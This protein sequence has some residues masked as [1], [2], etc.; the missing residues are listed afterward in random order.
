MTVAAIVWLGYE[1]WRLL[2]QQ[3]YLGARDLASLQH[4]SLRWFSDSPPYGEYPPP[5]YALL[6]PLIAWIPFG[7]ARWVWAAVM[8]AALAALSMLVLK[9]SQAATPEERRVAA[10]MPPSM[11]AAGAAIGNGQTTVPILMIL[12][13]GVL[14]AA[15]R[16]R[17]WISDLLAALLLIFALTKPTIAA[18]FLWIVLFVPGSVRPA[19]FV[20]LGY[21]AVFAFAVSV[22]PEGVM[23]LLQGWI[24]RAS[25]MASRPGQGNVANLHIVLTT[26][27]LERWVLPAGLLMLLVL[28]AWIFRYRRADIWLLMGVTAYVARFW[29]YHRW[30]DDLLILL[31]MIAMFRLAKHPPR[32][33][34]VAGRLLAITAAAMLAPGGLFLFPPPL[35]S[36]YVVG[37][38]IIWL[39]GMCFLI[40]RTIES[41]LPA[42][43]DW[44]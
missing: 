2:F 10:L 6:W 24:S 27:G 22:R 19:M 29:S 13:T 32:G 25:L 26:L 33:D 34:V 3:G 43:A 30:Y 28:G 44:K 1:F 17:R 15:R 7:I 12:I 21:L 37:Q 38:V 23:T 20:G 41:E 4:Q 8:V 31:P 5:S 9:Y 11:Y 18:P 40:R 35:N 39:A 42:P 16:E 36:V 14:I